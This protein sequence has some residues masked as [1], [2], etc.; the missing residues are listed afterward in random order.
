MGKSITTCVAVVALAMMCLG[1]DAQAK[2]GPVSEAAGKKQAAGFCPP[3]PHSEARSKAC[4]NTAGHKNQP[5]FCD[6]PPP[7]CTPAGG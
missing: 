3:A 2:K 4:P 6:P 1:G 5:P 7:D